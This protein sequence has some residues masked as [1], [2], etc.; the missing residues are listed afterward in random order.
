MSGVVFKTAGGPSGDFRRDATE[1]NGGSRE[2]E[3]GA[4]LFAELG[5]GSDAGEPQE[6]GGLAGLGHPQPEPDVKP[7]EPAVTAGSSAAS[8]SNSASGDGLSS[9]DDLISL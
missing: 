7:L 9:T 4:D 8:A 2:E 6:S 5:L 3:S 1:V